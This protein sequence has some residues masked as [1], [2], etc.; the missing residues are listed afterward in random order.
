MRT[1]FR[2]PLLFVSAAAVSAYV[3]L[4]ATAGATVDPT[5][6]A[7]SDSVV[8]FFTS[9]LGI[10]IGAFISVAGVLW[11]LALIFRSVGLHR[12]RSVG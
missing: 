12:R 11:L 8:S 5:L 6:S 9:N 3:T 10:A 4:A 1:F 2:N 7:A